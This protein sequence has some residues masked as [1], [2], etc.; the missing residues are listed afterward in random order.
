MMAIGQKT[1]TICYYYSCCNCYQKNLLT[2]WKLGPYHHLFIISSVTEGMIATLG[3]AEDLGYSPHPLGKYMPHRQWEH[4]CLLSIQ[5]HQLHVPHESKVAADV[6]A[7]ES[8]AFTQQHSFMFPWSPAQP[9]KTGRLFTG[10]LS[11]FKDQHIQLKELKAVAL[12]CKKIGTKRENA[13]SVTNLIEL[14]DY[15]ICAHI[16]LIK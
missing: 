8:V 1:K 6:H 11:R 9:L 4:R 14:F 13:F 5:H 2:L 10:M 12:K 15:L 16:L 3:V 7:S